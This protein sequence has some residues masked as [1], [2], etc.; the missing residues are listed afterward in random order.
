[1]LEVLS[2]N[3]AEGAKF[4]LKMEKIDI[5]VIKIKNSFRFEIPVS[6]TPKYKNS[7]NLKKIS[8]FYTL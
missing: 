3:S 8:V 7:D 2:K 4:F 1:M 5:L 6:E